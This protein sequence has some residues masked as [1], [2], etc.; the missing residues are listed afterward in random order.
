MPRAEWE[1]A[2]LEYRAKHGD[3]DSDE[4]NENEWF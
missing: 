2:V 1:A 4:D 3:D